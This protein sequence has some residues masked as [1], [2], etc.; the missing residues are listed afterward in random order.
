MEQ[1][2]VDFKSLVSLLK[3]PNDKDRDESDDEFDKV[4]QAEIFKPI[5]FL[6]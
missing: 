1:L 6:V 2:N 4:K 3:N 5:L